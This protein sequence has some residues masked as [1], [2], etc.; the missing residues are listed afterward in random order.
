MRTDCTVRELFD[1][2]VDPNGVDIITVHKG[3]MV[4]QC[5]N[6]ESI[7]LLFEEKVRDYEVDYYTD[8]GLVYLDIY[9]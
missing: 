4:H 7:V 9:L 6:K 3:N 8:D 1:K 5:D 2:V